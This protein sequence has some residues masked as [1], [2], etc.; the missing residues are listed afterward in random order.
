MIYFISD[1]HGG[2]FMA[3]LE[4]YVSVAQKD[5]LLVILGDIG[6]NFEKTE[7]NRR[8]T[9]YFESLDINVAFLDGNHENHP[10]IASFPEDTWCGA[11]VHRISK[12]IVHLIRG[13]VYEIEGKSFLVMGGCKSSPKWKEMGLWFE[14]EEPSDAELSLAYY[15]LEKY[16]GK[17]DYILTHK[18]FRERPEPSP[19]L[20]LEGLQ[21]YIDDN[22]T[23]RHWYSGH[24]HD[25]RYFDAKHTFVFDEPIKLE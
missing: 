8:F 17:I 16:G 15:N 13:N 18:Y 10:Y 7:E 3:G 6:I 21:N 11:K 23:Y 14:G 12:N 4:K 20:T 22:V 1:L 5:D 9:E 24:W 25:T 19:R 2:E